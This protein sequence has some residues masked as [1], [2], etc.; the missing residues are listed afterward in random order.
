MKKK[1]FIV[2]FV[3]LL[4]VV[5]LV[6]WRVIPHPFSALI[7]SHEDDFTSF[8]GAMQ[9]AYVEN[10]N[11]RIDAY[12][13]D[14]SDNAEKMQELIAILESSKYR[15]D[16]RNLLPWEGTSSS[17]E[18]NHGV[19]TV[20]FMFVWGPTD[21]VSVT[22]QEGNLLVSNGAKI[23]VYHPTNPEV[24]NKMEEYM[25]LYGDKVEESTE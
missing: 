5:L 1:H 17:T 11:P 18:N 3:V 8:A 13:I 22:F 2:V 9:I 24:L 23:S 25:K 14:T 15:H 21:S 16:F 10:G 19:R 12:K 6:L 20:T 4:L 7:S